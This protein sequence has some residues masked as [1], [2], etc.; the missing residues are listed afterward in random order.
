MTDSQRPV[1]ASASVFKSGGLQSRTRCISAKIRSK[2]DD[3]MLNS[4][5]TEF[6]D[7]VHA[8][9]NASLPSPIEEKKR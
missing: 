5:R 6:E 8:N 2:V 3:V 7:Y 1:S 9:Y 4:N